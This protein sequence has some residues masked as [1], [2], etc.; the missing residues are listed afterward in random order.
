MLIAPLNHAS[1]RDSDPLH[2]L[3]GL[4][5]SSILLLASC[6]SPH[7]RALVSRELFSSIWLSCVWFGQHRTTY[8][9]TNSPHRTPNAQHLT[10]SVLAD[11]AKYLFQY[12]RF[13]VLVLSCIQ[14]FSRCFYPKRIPSEAENNNQSIRSKLEWCPPKIPQN[15]QQM[16]SECRAIAAIAS[17]TQG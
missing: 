4:P 14:S 11:T 6:L 9:H 8:T 17:G 16:G 15:Q 12:R 3:L 13:R 7:V 5:F 2:L 10:V 1:T